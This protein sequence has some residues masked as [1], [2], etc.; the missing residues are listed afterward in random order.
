MRKIEYV[1]SVML[2]LLVL[3]GMIA[4]TQASQHGDATALSCRPGR[5][6]APVVLKGMSLYPRCPAGKRG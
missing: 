1:L 6:A 5:S 2:A 4:W 3:T